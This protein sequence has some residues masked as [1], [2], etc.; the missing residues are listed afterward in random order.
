V[1]MAATLLTTMTIASDIL[2]EVHHGPLSD[3]QIEILLPLRLELF[4]GYPYLYSG[5]PERERRNWKSLPPSTIGIFAYYNTRLVG[6]IIAYEEDSAKH[7]ALA[8]YANYRPGK[9]LHVDLIMVTKEYRKYGVAR[10]LQKHFEV[11]AR[12]NGY[13]DLYGI[14]VVRSA[15]HPLKPEKALDLY[16]LFSRAGFCALP[17]YETWNWPTRCGVPGNE[18]VAPIDNMVQY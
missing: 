12:K 5:N 1:H 4:Y 8:G 9:G 18:F 17:L 14:T 6:V 15:N 2:Y 13:V 10:G 11:H 3:E 16:L 7:V